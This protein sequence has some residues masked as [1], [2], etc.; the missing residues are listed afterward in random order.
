MGTRS[1]TIVYN[2][3]SKTKLVCMY[4]QFDGY[5]TGHGKELSELLDGRVIVNG[6]GLDDT[7]N[8]KVSNGMGCLAATIIANFKDGI[9]GIYIMPPTTKDAG[10]DY[11]Y[12]VYNDNVIVKG[13]GKVVFKGDY[14]AFNVFCNTPEK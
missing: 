13:Y 14:S 9:G 10:Q 11:E 6:F 5:P 4:R 12:H 7:T 2:D 3:N 1:L 8:S